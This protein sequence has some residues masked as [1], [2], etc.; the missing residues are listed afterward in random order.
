[1]Q[2]R[3]ST[4]YLFSISWWQLAIKR[5]LPNVRVLLLPAFLLCIS[6]VSLVAWDSYLG[7][8]TL[9]TLDTDQHAMDK[10]GQ[11]ALILFASGVFGLLTGLL[12]LHI[13]L[14]DLTGIARLAMSPDAQS[15]TDLLIELKQKRSYFNKLWLIGFAFLVLPIL[16]LS[17][18]LACSELAH[19]NLQAF[20][21]PLVPIPPESV[22]PM[23]CVASLL[24]LIVLDFSILLLVLSSRTNLSPLA[25]NKLALKV[26]F[27]NAAPVWILNAF[28]IL[29][30]VIISVPLFVLEFIP[31]CAGISKNLVLNIVSQIWFALS[32]LLCWPLSVMMFAEFLKP[33]VE[34]LEASEGIIQ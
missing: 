18:L 20:G 30:N 15:L 27:T 7:T 19:L 26:L 28:L 25:A 9:D 14:V 31:G 11:L 16:V 10:L 5:I 12:S 1:M 3:V 24:I 4:N 6:N 29:L 32:S 8:L 34:S 23:N 13:W 17:V 2:M 21:Q 33:M 22:L